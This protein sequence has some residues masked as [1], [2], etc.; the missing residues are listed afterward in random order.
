MANYATLKSS[1]N[2][3]ITTNGNNE[4]TGAL[5]N[6]LL[7]SIIDAL[8]AGYQYMGIATPTTNPGTPDQRVLYL[9][10]TAGTYANFNGIV[11]QD[12]EVALLRY[13]TSWHKD[14]SG[15]AT[16]QA[17]NT[18]A[19]LSFPFFTG[20]DNTFGVN[21]KV[22]P[23]KAGHKYRLTPFVK[24]WEHSQV[25]STA[26]KL[27]IGYVQPG[28]TNVYPVTVATWDALQESYEIEM[29]ATLAEG[30]FLAIGGRANSGVR[31]YFILEDLTDLESLKE[32]ISF[33]GNNNSYARSAKNTIPLKAG[34]VY[35]F[36]PTVQE[37]AHDNV[38]GTTANGT[39]IGYFANNVETILYGSV[40]GAWTFPEYYDIKIP[41]NVTGAVARVGGRANLGTVVEFSI[42]DVTD[43]AE[44]TSEIF[45]PIVEKE[46]TL[47]SGNN[48]AYVECNLK[49]GEDYVMYREFAAS[50]MNL[51]AGSASSSGLRIWLSN[52]ATQGGT[53]IQTIEQIFYQNGA[54]FQR[55]VKF[56]ASA[57]ARYL[58][59]FVNAKA[60]NAGVTYRLG[61]GKEVGQSV[62]DLN[63]AVQN[64]QE[65]VEIGRTGTIVT[66]GVN[67]NALTYF[68]PLAGYRYLFTFD[69]FTKSL[70]SNTLKVQIGYYPDADN[71]VDS[72]FVVLRQIN[73][74][75]T[76]DVD[77]S[78]FKDLVYTFPEGCAARIVLRGDAGQEVNY[79]I[80][81]VEYQPR[82]L[83]GIT[84]QYEGRKIMPYGHKNNYTETILSVEGIGTY[85][86]LSLQGFAIYD[87]YAFITYD[88]GYIRI[89]DLDTMQIIATYAMPTGVQGPNNHAGMATFGYEFYSATDDFPL[90]YVSSYLENKCYVLRVTL[91][92]CSLIQTIT[93]ANAWHFLVDDCGRLIVHMNDWKTYYIFNVPSIN[94]Q[95]VTLQVSDAIDTFQFVTP[96]M[97]TAGTFCQDGKMYILCYYIGS[98]ENG[99]YDRLV[100]Y[101]YEKKQVVS[102]IIFEDP[103][104]RTHEFEGMSVN[105]DG[106]IVISFVANRL[107]VLE[108]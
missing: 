88:T 54:P 60:A 61:V 98:V 100:V 102:T 75:T 26:N 103:Q 28:S 8:G 65:N 78:Q 34:H 11:L 5:L 49:A 16:E 23:I 62:L 83:Y 81:M 1:V 15:L 96:G 42:E 104:I 12:N 95:D 31:V 77:V 85:N 32:T 105:N 7:M 76:E 79:R 63:N 84:R 66:D 55:K 9:A 36:T 22:Y 87:K 20:A 19:S 24:E 56:T 93:M 17:V 51:N 107:A 33:T 4:I 46:G 29:P 2:S 72:S 57:N 52:Q 92:G 97:N 86:G 37:W 10:R 70:L 13:D 53:T 21:E 106:N 94:T 91:T 18:L 64:L 58:C 45:A 25:T 47:A 69:N 38:T 48:F 3:V 30:S 68:K 74:T 39:A 50:I 101:N 41:D 108:F 14:N 73:N 80:E 6:S 67:T 40:V 90:L 89:L 35:R 99:K 59:F 27:G 44:I 43:I 71:K 82:E